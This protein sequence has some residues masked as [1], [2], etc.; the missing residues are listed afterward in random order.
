ME[1]VRKKFILNK[2]KQ[3]VY[4]LKNTPKSINYGLQL[5]R[6]PQISLSSL[7]KIA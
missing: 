7:L 2:N 4:I 1:K 3:H 6:K 5:E